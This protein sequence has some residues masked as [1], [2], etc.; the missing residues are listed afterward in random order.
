MKVLITTSS[1]AAYSAEPLDQLL[2]KGYEAVLNPFKT[3]ITK[4]QAKQL[5]REDVDGVIAGTEII[6]KEILANAKR[7]KVIS[8]CGTGVDNIDISFAK[9]KGIRIFATPDAP[10]NAVAE[11][12]V[13]L[14]LSLLRWIPSIDRE[15]CKGGWKK[16]M[17]GLLQSKNIGIVGFGRIGKQTAKLLESFDVKILYCDP[18]VDVK[19]LNGFRRVSLYELLKT[20]DIVSLH[21]SYSEENHKLIS[22]KELSL[23]KEGAF[24]VN[25]SRGGIVDEQALYDALKS[26]LLA[27]AALDVFENEPYNGVLKELDNVIL[28]PHIGSYAKEARIEMEIEAVRNLLHGLEESLKIK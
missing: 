6:D 4:E 5:Y 1:F 12:T 7:L 27:G 3:K 16:K 22:Q 28:T 10:T 9:K 24:L 13:G 8:R 2:H 11:L 19:G 14:I 26:G 25:T 15:I 18:V 21:L 20:S 17:G 23:M